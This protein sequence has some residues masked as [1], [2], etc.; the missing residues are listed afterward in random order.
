[1][2]PD[3]RLVREKKYTYQDGSGNVDQMF[4]LEKG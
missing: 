2:F 4:L 3:L 1:L